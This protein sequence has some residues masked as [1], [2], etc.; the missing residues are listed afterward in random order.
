MEDKDL[1]KLGEKYKIEDIKGEEM[2][3]KLLEIL[4]KTRKAKELNGLER[5]KGLI[6]ETQSW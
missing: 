6:I 4:E 5:I 1:V 2:N 3:K